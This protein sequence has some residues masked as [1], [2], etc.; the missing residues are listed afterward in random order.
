[1]LGRE[2][3][4]SFDVATAAFWLFLAVV[5]GSLI[6]RKALQRREA[7]I[8]LRAAI[9]KG[10]ALDDERLAM[11]LAAASGERQRKVLSPE[12]FLVFGAFFAAAALFLCVLAVLIAFSSGPGNPAPVAVF[13]LLAGIVAGTFF[14]LWRLLRRQA[15]RDARPRPSL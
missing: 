4:M 10:L 5:V 15:D 1:M 2:T 6:W 7:M 8:T 14:V 13:A 3:E 9:E 12:F 11:L